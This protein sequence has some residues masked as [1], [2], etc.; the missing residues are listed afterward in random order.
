MRKLI[1]FAS[2][3]LAITAS[4]PAYIESS[5][6]QTLVGN[7]SIGSIFAVSSLLTIMVLTYLPT[8]L[9]RFGLKKPLLFFIFL[10]VFSLIQLSL[11]PAKYATVFAFIIYYAVGMILRYLCDI[12]LEQYSTDSDTGIT[13]GLYMTALNLAW[14]VS[15]FVAGRVLYLRPE[16]YDLIFFFVLVVSILFLCFAFFFIKE[17]PCDN[18]KQSSPW[19]AL[20]NIWRG[21]DRPNRDLKRILSI[22]FLLHFFYSLMVVYSPIYLHQVIMMSWQSIGIIFTFMLLPFVLF[23]APL[24][25]L[26]DRYWG[27]K[28]VLIYSIIILSIATAA[29]PF[30]RSQSLIIWSIVLFL[31]RTGAAGMEIMTETYLFK[32]IDSK[33]P[34][35]IAISRNNIPLA[36]IIGPI[37]ATIFLT[38]FPLNS[39]FPILAL[40]T[41]IGIW[42]AQGLKD[43]K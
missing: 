39:I 30:I 11:S 37:F 41:T 19:Q 22:N 24:G 7:Q 40:I 18:F 17:K 25:R 26:A 29:I 16:R 34:D 2:F 36:Y 15:P 32:K 35:I 6:L 33:N 14:L 20:K 12:L 28:E 10:L 21:N 13:R 5:F 43:T 27:E 1:Y 23:E 42:L 3:L 8:R 31:T 9:H 4:L 38:I